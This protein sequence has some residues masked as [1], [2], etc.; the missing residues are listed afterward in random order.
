[1]LFTTSDPIP[2]PTT[3]SEAGNIPRWQDAM[4]NELLAL[5]G[6]KTWDLV[7]RPPNTSVIGS[8][9]VYSIKVCSD[10]NI[11]HNKAQLVA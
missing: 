6:N 1:M 7:P 2:I 3:Y 4:T 10:G 5:E 8:K 11:N 9:W